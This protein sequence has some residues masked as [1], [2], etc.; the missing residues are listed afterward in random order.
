MAG[1]GERIELHVYGGTTTQAVEIDEG[2]CPHCCFVAEHIDAKAGEVVFV[3][4]GPGN[5]DMRRVEAVLTI[6]QVFGL[7]CQRVTAEEV[8][9]EIRSLCVGSA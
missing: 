3:C 5:D 9:A 1:M 6:E 7:V 4:A 2:D 8:E